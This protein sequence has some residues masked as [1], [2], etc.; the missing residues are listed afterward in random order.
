[1]LDVPL[2]QTSGPVELERSGS[3]RLM[4]VLD[5]RRTDVIVAALAEADDA[6]TVNELS[7]RCDIPLSTVY[8]KIDAL[9]EAALVES[10]SVLR[11]DGKHTSSYTLTVERIEVELT[12]EGLAATVYPSDEG[13]ETRAEPRRL[14][15]GH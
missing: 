15:V 6:L 9:E 14:G 11:H 7:E 8:R 1:M 4:A 13:D 5:D 2:A 10:H 3:R 12:P